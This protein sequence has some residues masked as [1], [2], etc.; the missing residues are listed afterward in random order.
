VP[1]VWLAPA[2]FVRVEAVHAEAA[3]ASFAEV[4]VSFVTASRRSLALRS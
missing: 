3:L 1:A 2:E 4:V